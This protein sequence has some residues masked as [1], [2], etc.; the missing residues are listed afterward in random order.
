VIR[1]ENQSKDN[2]ND[3]TVSLEPETV[4]ET[5]KRKAAGS[6]EAVAA[7]GQEAVSLTN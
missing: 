2:S 3:K 4:R 1:K 5:R 6:P 7:G